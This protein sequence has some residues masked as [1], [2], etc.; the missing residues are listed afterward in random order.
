MTGCKTL[1]VEAGL[2]PVVTDYWWGS[3]ET[4][5]DADCKKPISELR[6]G[7]INGDGTTYEIKYVRFCFRVV[8][9]VPGKFRFYFP[10]ILPS[11]AITF[12]T[13]V[14]FS[15]AGTFDVTSPVGYNEWVV[16]TYTISAPTVAPW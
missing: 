7:T 1:V 5:F 14:T 4:P 15:S 16:G 6:S 2:L 10:L 12:Q 11:G 3:C 9:T 8:V 13:A